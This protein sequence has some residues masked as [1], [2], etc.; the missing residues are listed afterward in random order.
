MYGHGYAGAGIVD[1]IFAAVPLP[2]ILFDSLIIRGR[3]R[4]S[5]PTGSFI[6]TILSIL[7]L[8]YTMSTL[9]GNF[10][11]HSQPSGKIRIGFS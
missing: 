6:L 4:R 2:T 11:I 8:S 10:D 7:L 9:S 1:L 5:A 3:H